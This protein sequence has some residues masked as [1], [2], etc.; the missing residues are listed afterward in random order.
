MNVRKSILNYLILHSSIV[1]RNHHKSYHKEC[2]QRGSPNGME[3]NSKMKSVRPNYFVCIPLSGNKALV[4]ELLKVQNHVASKFEMLKECAIE[5][6]KFH[7]S[8]LILHVKKSQMESSKEAFHEAME[9]IKKLNHQAISFDTLETFRNDVLYAAL[10]EGSRNAANP[11]GKSAANPIGKSAANPIGKSAANPIGKSA[12]NPI[13]KSAA[14]PIDKSAANPIDKSAANPID[15]SAA[16]P[17]T[18]QRGDKEE[19][20]PHMTIMKNSYLRKIYANRKPQI[21]P[22]YYADFNLSKLQNERVLPNKIQF[23]E[24]DT[25]SA[26]S[27][28]RI[29]AECGLP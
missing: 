12:A 25:D 7:I 10:Q 13:G 17:S 1:R 6:N 24:M 22:D 23:L 11:I 19:I 5:R 4:E 14:N 16:S 29:I 18:H 8:L 26:T 20:T 27:Y 15:K 3:K 2:R 21:F 28:Y 9:E